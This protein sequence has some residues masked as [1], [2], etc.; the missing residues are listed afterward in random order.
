MS[1]EHI[2]WWVRDVYVASQAVED[3]VG[4]VRE[5]WTEDQGEPR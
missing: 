4:I 3:Y 2:E 1:M 5:L